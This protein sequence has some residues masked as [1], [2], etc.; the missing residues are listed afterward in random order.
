MVGEETKWAQVVRNL[1]DLCQA[2]PVVAEEAS[3][4]RSGGCGGGVISVREDD[5]ERQG[6]GQVNKVTRPQA[7]MESNVRGERK[8]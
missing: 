3:R 5:V 4:I 2:S 6:R 1:P 7:G 8:K